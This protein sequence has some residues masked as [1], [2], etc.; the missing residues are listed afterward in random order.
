M[1]RD[2]VTS[3]GMAAIGLVASAASTVAR[4]VAL[5]GRIVAAGLGTLEQTLRGGG[6]E[7]VRGLEGG[8]AIGG[9]RGEGRAGRAACGAPLHPPR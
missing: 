2:D 3:V 5:S 6:G 8:L 1:D 7:P 9:G 4:A